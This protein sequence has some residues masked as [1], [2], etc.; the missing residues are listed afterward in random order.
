MSANKFARTARA[1]KQQTRANMASRPSWRILY[2]MTRC[3]S[4]QKEGPGHDGPRPGPPRHPGTLGGHL[5]TGLKTTQNS[6]RS[7]WPPMVIV[8]FEA[9]A[10]GAPTNLVFAL[11]P[12]TDRR[13][14][15]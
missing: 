8:V 5:Q 2:S 11:A 7:F 15:G 9:A 1:T 3:L 4:R 10:C 13:V 14:S 12:R 6:G